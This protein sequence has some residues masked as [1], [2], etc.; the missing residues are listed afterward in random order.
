M[1]ESFLLS[2]MAPQVGAG[3]NNGIWRT[4]ENRVRTWTQ[5]RGELYIVAGPIFST[6]PPPRVPS[7]NVSVPSH[8][9]KVI[10]D[11]VRV[12]AIAF[13]LANQRTP[14]GQLP[15]FIV[16]VDTVEQR[17]GLDFLSELQNGVESL[18]EAQVAPAMW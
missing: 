14:S 12:E 17:T 10:F 1:S 7:G 11:P 8:F 18:V 13:I 16:N 4:L 6:I 9:Y 3:F 2:N 5:D 15:T